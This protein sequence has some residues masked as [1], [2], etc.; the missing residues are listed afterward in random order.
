M[1]VAAVVLLFRAGVGLIPVVIAGAARRSA[2]RSE[3]RDAARS[4]GLETR[5]FTDALSGDGRSGVPP[6]RDLER[7]VL[8]RGELRRDVPAAQVDQAARGVVVRGLDARTDGTVP[9]PSL[10]STPSDDPCRRLRRSTRWLAT[11]TSPA[12]GSTAT[13]AAARIGALADSEPPSSTDRPASSRIANQP[14][15]AAHAEADAECEPLQDP[16]PEARA[17]HAIAHSCPHARQRTCSRCPTAR[18]RRTTRSERELAVGAAR[19]AS[20][21]LR[22]DASCFGDEQLPVEAQPRVAHSAA[23]APPMLRHVRKPPS[24]SRNAMTSIAMTS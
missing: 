19:R 4:P 1:F 20:G 15:A 9:S 17:G 8:A 16:A 23:P 21:G 18:A 2:S 11:R 12:E 22:L 3:V 14:R 24:D 7:L 10:R 13:G 5:S 6:A